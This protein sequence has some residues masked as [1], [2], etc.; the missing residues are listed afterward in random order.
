MGD[1]E[2]LKIALQP[3]ALSD[4]AWEALE[5]ELDR[6]DLELPEPEPTPQTVAPEKRSLF[7]LRKFRDSP[8][9]LLAKGSLD[10]A[11]IESF[12]GDENMVRLDWFISNLLGGIKLL[13]NAEDAAVANE[14]LNQPIPENF[15]VEGIGDFQQPRCPQCQSVDVSFE[16]LYKP[17]AYGSLFVSLPV[18]V[19][20][21]G[22]ICQS[23]RH[24]WQEDDPE[25]NANAI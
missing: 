25:N 16:E 14:I 13:V 7:L 19:H 18:P 3:W 17:L 24:T 9:A 2:L 10:S 12:L 11:G 15:D 20:R 22:W 5:D 1:G 21:K 6:R 8:E 4:S 23:C